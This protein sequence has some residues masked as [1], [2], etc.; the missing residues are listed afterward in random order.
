MAPH[1]CIHHLSQRWTYSFSLCDLTA[2]PVALFACVCSQAL[3]FHMGVFHV[4]A[5]YTSRGPR[6]IE[7]NAR[8]GGGPVR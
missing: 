6:L 8:M 4:E 7:V 2:N 1:I 5:K 3:G